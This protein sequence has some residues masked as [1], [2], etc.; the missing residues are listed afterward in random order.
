MDSALGEWIWRG[1]RIMTFAAMGAVLFV[2]AMVF[3]AQPLNDFDLAI[4]GRDAPAWMGSGAVPRGAI[5]MSH[6]GVDA[7]KFGAA[8]YIPWVGYLWWFGPLGLALFFV[9]GLAIAYLSRIPFEPRA[10]LT[11]RTAAVGV[12][13][14]LFGMAAWPPFSCVM[15]IE[16]AGCFKPEYGFAPLI[17]GCYV[18]GFALLPRSLMLGAAAGGLLGL[19]I[20]GFVVVALGPTE[21]PGLVGPGP[22]VSETW[23]VI[24]LTTAVG[25]AAGG[26]VVSLDRQRERRG[27]TTG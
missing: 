20:G 1:V 15:Y 27:P 26:V 8:G 16:W 11:P 2:S 4:A 22:Y 23:W 6:D 9:V 25:A 18:L 14:A 19:V 3:A 17:L 10:Y 12:S 7:T 5:M 13:I 21:S 24:P